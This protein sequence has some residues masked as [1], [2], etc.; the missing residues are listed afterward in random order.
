LKIVQ[1]YLVGGKMSQVF[2]NRA[3]WKRGGLPV[4]W[5]KTRGDP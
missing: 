1:L 2:L 3:L 4:L 5:R